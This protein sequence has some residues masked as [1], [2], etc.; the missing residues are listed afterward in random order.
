MHADKAWCVA[1]RRRSSRRLRGG[2]GVGFGSKEFWEAKPP[3][4]W[5]MDEI[6]RMLAKSPWA[7]DASVMS[8][9]PGFGNGGVK[10]DP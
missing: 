6:D 1:V 10:T 2:A 4:E 7:K 8:N 5:T 3:S 9:G